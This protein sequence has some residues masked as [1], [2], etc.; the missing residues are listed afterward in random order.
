MRIFRFLSFF[1]LMI[2][3]TSTAAP[4]A[5]AD[6]MDDLKFNKLVDEYLDLQWKLSPLNAT[7]NGIHIYD[8]QI[9]SFAL[10]AARKNLE[11]NQ[12][13]VER[14]TSEIDRSKLSDSNQI[15]YDLIFQSLDAQEFGLDQSRDLEFDPSTY[16]NIVSGIGFLMFTRE[17][18]PFPERMRNLQKRMEKMP[19]ILEEG[20]QNLKNPPK[21]WTQI[22][23]QTT[24]GG[25]QLYQQLISPSAK[26]L[27]EPDQKPFEDA[28]AKVVVALQSYQQYLEKDLLPRST[29]NFADGCEKFTYRLK[30]F[31]LIDKSP[32]E[33]QATASESFRTDQSGHGSACK[34]DGPRQNLVGN[35]SGGQEETFLSQ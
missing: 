14:F 28:A 26:Q 34:K 32:A 31:Y 9:E 30:H 5:G 19:R 2:L 16:P 35:S 24:Q 11:Q 33:I 10:G 12:Q 29:G 3:I 1:S 27:P 8:D 15:D 21:L 20:K 25:I 7:L 13:F 6:S 4:A 17:Y 18:A 23:I 22:A